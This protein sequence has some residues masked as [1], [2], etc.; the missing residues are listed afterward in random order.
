MQK[1][2][3]YPSI[4]DLRDFIENGTQSEKTIIY[5]G[6]II[7][8]SYRETL[9]NMSSIYAA[10]SSVK[11]FH[12]LM[13][14]KMLDVFSYLSPLTESQDSII[15]MADCAEI[16]EIK[17]YIKYTLSGLIDL[18]D[19]DIPDQLMISE[20]SKLYYMCE[21]FYFF[22]NKYK[23]S[24]I[25]SDLRNNIS[26]RFSDQM[27]MQLNEVISEMVDEFEMTDKTTLIYY[28]LIKIYEKVVSLVED[29][30]IIFFTSEI[31][32]NIQ[33]KYYSNIFKNKSNEFLE[34]I[35]KIFLQNKNFYTSPR[36]N[37]NNNNHTD[38]DKPY[39]QRCYQNV[40]DMLE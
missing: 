8:N 6:E 39:R 19:D 24:N 26:N 14:D 2:E 16:D 36:E 7:G 11:N 5:S 20:F 1:I 23:N 27:F 9:E 15:T 10:M 3:I 12:I 22:E 21:F 40:I 28:F 30:M 38:Y 13:S 18:E 35:N 33:G 34:N 32:V 29:N 31:S 25:F 4:Y 17:K 37:F